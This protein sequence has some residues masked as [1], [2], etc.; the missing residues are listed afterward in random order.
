MS[1]LPAPRVVP[2]LAPKLEKTRRSALDWQRA[3]LELI[4]EQGVSAVAVETL[5]RRMSVTKGSFYWHF[6]SRDALLSAALAQWE[7][8]DQEAL[9]AMLSEV[10]QPKERLRELFR[11]TSRRR[12][13][14]A[15][16]A[17]LI[18]AR[19][20]P[21]ACD[22]LQ[23]TTERRMAFLAAE[24]VALGMSAGEAQ[25]RAR[26]TYAAYVGFVQLTPHS[27]SAR[28]STEQY[29]AYVEHTISTLIP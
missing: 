24:F 13:T 25:H 4:A 6:A 5:A 18:A 15:I 23:R 1:A 10:K 26:L 8:Q 22:V 12:T 16:Y 11:R 29:D 27:D 14:H 19:E 9:R 28:L 17:A 20:H 3:A 21:L 7:K 2:T